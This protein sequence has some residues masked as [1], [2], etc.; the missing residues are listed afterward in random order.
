MPT[1]TGVKQVSTTRPNEN[2]ARRWLNQMKYERDQGIFHEPSKATLGSYLDYWLENSVKPSVRPGTYERYEA[3]VRRHI[4]PDLGRAKLHDIKLS[5]L[6]ALYQRKIDSGLSP[7]TVE[8]IHRTTYRALKEAVRWDMVRTNA[9]A[10]ARSPRAKPKE[11]RPLSKEEAYALL[12]AAKGTRLKA[13][14]I[15]ALAT[16]M[17]RGEMLGLKWDDLDLDAGTLQVRRSLVAAQGGISVG[18]PKRQSSKRRLEL[19]KGTV[20]ALKAHRARQ[21]EERLAAAE[22]ADEG[23]VF[24]KKDG[25][26]IAPSTFVSVYFEPLIKRAGLWGR[27]I[28]FHDLRHTFATNSLLQNIPVKVV[29]ETLGH[30]DVSIT[31]KTYSHVLPGMGR[32]AA[33]KMDDFLFGDN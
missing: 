29:S 3:I 1:P 22:Y 11:M 18:E 27:G 19:G 8:Y 9:A 28:R 33:D 16:G 5:D 25:G 32:D 13:L 26:P 12:E 4:K 31:L 6:E 10:H 14:F 20:A 21:K 23:W 2:E 7:R 24:A 15:L 30:G 17:R